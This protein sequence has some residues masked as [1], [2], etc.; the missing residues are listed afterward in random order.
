M[1]AQWSK[2]TYVPNNSRISVAAEYTLVRVCGIIVTN[3]KGIVR[4]S[5]DVLERAALVSVDG[6]DHSLK[7]LTHT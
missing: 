3:D 2:E 4:R 1:D 6:A 5:M 7:N